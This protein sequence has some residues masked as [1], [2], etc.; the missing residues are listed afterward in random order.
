MKRSLL[1]IALLVSACDSAGVEG[2]AWI[3]SFEGVFVRSDQIITVSHSKTV[4]SILRFDAVWSFDPVLNA[5]PRP[6]DCTADS[7]LQVPVLICV[8]LDTEF[9]EHRYKPHAQ[10]LMRQKQ[11]GTESL[12]ERQL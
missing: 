2:N 6:A 11:D 5:D 12:Y 7:D 10:G 3:D 1:F 8:Y 9:G 4:G